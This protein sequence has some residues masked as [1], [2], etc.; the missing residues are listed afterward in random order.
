MNDLRQL[1]A[2]PELFIVDVAD[3]MLSTLARA[4]LLEHPALATDTIES[5][6]GIRARE[7]INAVRPLRRAL[8]KYR[9]AVHRTLD[10]LEHDLPF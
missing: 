9:C 10:D 1:A 2:A 6:V 7:I 4:L 5:D 3:Q 8:A